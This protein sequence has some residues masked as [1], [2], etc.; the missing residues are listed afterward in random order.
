MTGQ[1]RLNPETNTHASY[2]TNTRLSTYQVKLHI[3]KKG[4]DEVTATATGA[5]SLAADLASRLA[6]AKILITSIMLIAATVTVPLAKH[7]DAR[8]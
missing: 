5:L 8:H 6:T 7:I 1:H 3:R 2:S 4:V